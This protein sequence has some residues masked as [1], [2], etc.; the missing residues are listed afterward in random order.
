MCVVGGTAHCR[1]VSL[2]QAK[3]WAEHTYVPSTL[4]YVL[5][6][7]IL[8]KAASS[9]S[10]P[11]N[12]RERIKS[13]RIRPEVCGG[14]SDQLQGNEHIFCYKPLVACLFLQPSLESVTRA[15]PNSFLNAEGQILSICVQ[16][17]WASET[18]HKGPLF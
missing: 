12:S 1:R 9:V 18:G 10:H 3:G 15:F 14:P 17:M 13:Q 7:V 11:V 2:K 8:T 16:G 6:V 5:G 4:A